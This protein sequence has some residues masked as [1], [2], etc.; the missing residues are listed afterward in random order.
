MSRNAL[1]EDPV[2]ALEAERE[3]AAWTAAERRIFLDK[4]LQFPKVCVLRL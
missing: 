4:F 1:V 3:T 2:A